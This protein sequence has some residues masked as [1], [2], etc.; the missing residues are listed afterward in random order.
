VIISLFILE[1][2]SVLIEIFIRMEILII[3][4]FPKGIRHS[5]SFYCEFIIK[6][7]EH[8]LEGIDKPFFFGRQYLRVLNMRC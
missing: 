4:A 5:N 8:F 1:H 6:R 3:E 2:Y 7:L